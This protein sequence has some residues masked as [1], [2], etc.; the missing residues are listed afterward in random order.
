M[1]PGYTRRDGSHGAGDTA[2][3]DPGARPRVRAPRRRHGR[4]PL[5]RQRRAR[6]LR[7]A[8]DGAGR[9]RRG[10]D[11]LPDARPPRD[12]VRAQRVPLPHPLPDLRRARVVPAPGRLVQRVLDAIRARDR[13]LLH[14]GARGRPLAGRQARR[15]LVR[16]RLGRARGDDAGGAARRSTST[17]SRPTSGWSSRASPASSRARCCRS[18]RTRSS[19]GR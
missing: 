7:A 14:P 6:Q 19:S 12:A 13:R 3:H 9:R 10:P 5:G 15:L 17:P 18:A 16:A 2:R 1:C 4:R 8:K 11:P